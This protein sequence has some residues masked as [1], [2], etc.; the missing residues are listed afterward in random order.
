MLLYS[1]LLY[2]LAYVDWGAL[3]PSCM[4][5][6]SSILAPVTHITSAACSQLLELLR[7]LLAEVLEVDLHD[8]LDQVVHLGPVLNH[9]CDIHDLLALQ[10][11]QKVPQIL[12]YFFLGIWLRLSC[13]SSLLLG[14]RFLLL[15][16]LLLV[17]A[18]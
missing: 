7:A 12:H 2:L 17:G 9:F 11:V 13:G 5:Y 1:F 4:C 6:G 3:A 8:L 14:S 18:S 16:L 15:L 10:E